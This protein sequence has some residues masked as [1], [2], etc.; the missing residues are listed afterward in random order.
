MT[1]AELRAFMNNITEAI[2]MNHTRY[3]PTLEGMERKIFRVVDQLEALD[4][5]ALVVHI[6]P[7]VHEPDSNEQ[8]E[9]AR[10]DE[11]LRCCLHRNRQSMGGNNANNHD[12]HNQDNRDPFS[13]V[14]FTIPAFYGTYDA[15]VYLD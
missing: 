11:E 4:L 2:S 9:S 6:P 12:D 7:A 15:E 8:D 14:K 3:A 13:K 5:K 10:R 1:Q